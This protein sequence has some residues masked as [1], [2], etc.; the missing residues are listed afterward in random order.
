MAQ[1][2]LGISAIFETIHVVG[3]EMS[4]TAKTK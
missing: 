2:F 1:H 4:F 3:A